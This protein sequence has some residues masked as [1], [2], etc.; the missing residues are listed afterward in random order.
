MKR[1]SKKP[2][3]HSFKLRT[4][5]LISFLMV[6][7][8]GLLLVGAVSVH[9]IYQFSRREVERNS[10][11]NL[12]MAMEHTLDRMLELRTDLIRPKV[13]P[14]NTTAIV[15]V[16]TS[17]ETSYENMFGLELQMSKANAVVDIDSLFYMNE[18]CVITQTRGSEM[19]FSYMMEK[20]WFS[21]WYHG[22]KT[23]TWGP[24]YQFQGNHVIP[25]VRKITS[26]GKTIGISLLNM[27]ESAI[28]ECWRAYGNI[29]LVDKNNYVL[30]A[31]YPDTLGKSFQEAYNVDLS[32]IPSESSFTVKHDGVNYHGIFYRE[33]AYG[34]GMV[35]L[36]PQSTTG[37]AVV[38]MLR[39]TIWI[40]VLVAVLC[41]VLAL[42]LSR[43]ITKPLQN[44]TEMVKNLK[45]DGVPA[46]LPITTN[47]EIGILIE[48]INDMTR[49]L[50]A[51]KQDILEISDARRLAEYRAIQL[52]INPHFL[53]NT[54]SSINWFAEQNQPEN[55]KKVADSLSMLFRISVNR[56]KEMLHIIE[57]IQHVRC[58]LDIQMLR[59][60]DEFTYQ[61]DVDPEILSY[62]TIKIILQPLVENSLYHGIRENG[63]TNGFIRVVG[64]RKGDNIELLV[65]DNGNTPQAEIDRMNMV[66]Q[67]PDSREDE[68]IG[69]LN[70]HNRIRYFYQNGYGLKYEKKDDLTIARVELPVVEEAKEDV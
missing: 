58:Y 51:S 16:L 33:N 5:L 46:D 65:I 26:Q 43:K 36:L 14:A 50:E 10:I 66:L 40:L 20:K 70:V 24:T 17:G 19:S 62:Y 59:H 30:S 11:A 49:R 63:V 68:G 42:L 6:A 1:T 64:R 7:L 21:A 61:I 47:D 4:K 28:Q 48:S 23:Y 44:A 56:G 8:L 55:V 67:N 60:K 57:E 52:Q 12:T 38:S 41:A 39:S 31:E 32:K 25:Y 13:Q 35:E 9:N 3:R 69:M 15:D 2:N 37:F 22:E 18:E 27:K 54:L 29:I 45:L 34:M 53:Y